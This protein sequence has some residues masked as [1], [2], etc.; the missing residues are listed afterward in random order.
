MEKCTSRRKM[1]EYFTFDDVLIRPAYSEIESRQDIDL[2]QDFLGLHLSIP[3]ISAN[4]DYVTGR[5]MAIAMRNEGGLGIIHRFG[6]WV[7]LENEIFEAAF[8]T[9]VA[10]FSVGTRFEE[11][12]TSHLDNLEEDL[13]RTEQP[14]KIVTVDVAHGHHRKVIDLVKRIKNDFPEW[15]VIAGN[16]ATAEGTSDLIAAGADAI[17]VGI[18]P[19]SVC[20]TRV[21]TG[22]GVPQLSAIIE[23]ADVA[24]EF[25]RPIIADGGIRSAGDIV[26]AIAAGADVVML[27]SLLAGTDEAPGEIIDTGR[28]K[29]VKRYQGQSIFGTNDALFTREGISGFVDSKGPVSGVLRQLMGGLRSGMSYVGARN[30]K[31]LRTNAEFIRISPSTQHENSTRISDYI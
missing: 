3:V 25:N 12:A 24:Y 1:K 10:A 26:K 11:E 16:V 19:G 9:G 27:G 18:G 28:G 8:A 13:A 17:K 2:G 29:R 4:M 6:D 21:V 14:V 23:C 30:L 22:I 5:Q 31:K 15:K 7:T 20:T